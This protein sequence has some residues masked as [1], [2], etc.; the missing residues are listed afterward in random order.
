MGTSSNRR[1]EMTNQVLDR[2]TNFDTQSREFY[3]VESGL[4]DLL[5]KAVAANGEIV[6]FS[7]PSRGVNHLLS[8]Y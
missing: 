1:G 6:L 2:N 5:E 3:K 7:R 8:F 4:K